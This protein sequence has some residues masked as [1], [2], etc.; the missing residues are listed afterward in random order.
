M[1][2]LQQKKRRKIVFISPRF[3]GGSALAFAGL[4]LAGAALFAVLVSR[5]V[6]QALW[7]AS[8]F[9]HYR[10]RSAY[11][12]AGP[13]LFRNLAGLFGGLLVAGVALYF[14]MLRRIRIGTDRIAAIFRL[15]GEGDLST[16][17]DAPGPGDFP[18][19]GKQ[20]DAVRGR[21]LEEIE[22]IRAEI[23][24]MRKESLT[25][26]EF[27]KRWEGVKERIRRIAP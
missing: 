2:A 27:Q 12:V 13:V 1:T 24:L 7:D 5:D 4:V 21:T 11:D 25:D 15:S 14:V 19:L 10:F 20:A 6:R 22:R 16:P 23:D 26:E 17:T 8:F 9:G 18:V 3:Q